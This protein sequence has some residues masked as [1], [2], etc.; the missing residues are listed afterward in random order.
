MF[1]EILQRWPEQCSDDILSAKSEVSFLR[2]NSLVSL[3]VKMFC[4]LNL[5]MFSK[6][7]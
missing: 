3:T 4:V 2:V 6:I 1:L 7:L 5:I